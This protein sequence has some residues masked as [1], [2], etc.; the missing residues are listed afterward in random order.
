MTEIQ[1]L[2]GPLDTAQLGRV[3][4]HEHIFN[5][6]YDVQ[7]EWPGFHGWD[8]D[9]EIPKAQ[10]KLRAVKAAGYDTILELSVLGLGRNI[11]LMQRALDGTGI[12][13]IVS[14]GA[15]TYDVL[16]RLWHFMGPGTMLGGDEPLD[17]LFQ[18]DIEEGIQGTGVKAGML[19]CAIDHGGMTEHV[20]RVMRACCRVHQQTNTPITVHTHSPSEQGL[21][22]LKVLQEEGVDPARVTFA[23]CGDT[24]DLDYLE[25]LAQTG[26][27]LGMDRFGLDILLPFD[28]RVATVVAMC[29]RGHAD[30]MVLSHDAISFSDWFP[31]G[32]EDQIT[33]N[34]HWLHIEN[35]V[36][37]A[38][39]ER[40]VTDEQIDQMLIHTP[41]AYFERS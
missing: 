39:R 32:L 31:P 20:E 6:T 36:L 33:P 14:T 3:L 28:D 35:D 30:Q 4:M 1:T 15:Y 9:A 41:R 40:G 21:A 37:P 24:T 23:H 18:R 34:W 17:E 19:K 7:G 26:A 8:P 12:Q 29:E 25:K 38:L 16:P 5:V 27:L 11:E 2:A 13:L 22:A 10:E